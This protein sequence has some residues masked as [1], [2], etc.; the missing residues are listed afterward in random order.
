MKK[1]LLLVG[2]SMGSLAGAQSY[3]QVLQC[4]DYAA[5]VDVDAH[6]RQNIQLVIRHAEVNEY[7]YSKGL[8]DRLL[9]GQQKCQLKQGVLR[10]GAPEKIIFRGR[11]EVLKAGESGTGS[12][13][14]KDVWHAGDLEFA[15]AGQDRSS[16]AVFRF[17]RDGQGLKLQ[18]LRAYSSYCQGGQDPS[19]GECLGRW[20]PGGL[21][22][23][24]YWRFQN[25]QQF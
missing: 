20:I 13:Y 16:R 7:L 15:H 4:D 14:Y 19:T 23:L 12:G 21:E 11:N 10:C 5:V 24:A 22:E 25:C 3:L 2:M 18:S 17:F 6:Q 9:A 1:V 8:Y